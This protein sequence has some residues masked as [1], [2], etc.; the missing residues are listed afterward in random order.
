MIKLTESAKAWGSSSF[1]EIFRNE[2]SQL[3]GR[4]LPLQE[5]ISQG[6]YANLEDFNVVVLGVSEQVKSIC[7]KA[8]I[9]Y[10]SVIAGCACSDDPAPENNL[11]EYCELQIDINKETA[12]TSISLF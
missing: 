11:P 8:G 2:V 3:D 6:S 4:L 12:E 10:S 7:V 5:A 9:F 1:K